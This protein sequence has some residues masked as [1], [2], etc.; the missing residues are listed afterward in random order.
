MSLYRHKRSSLWW[1]SIYHQGRRIRCSTGTTDKEKARLYHAK[2]TSDLWK[3]DKLQVT[4][5]HTWQ[6]ATM[7]WLTL[8]KRGQEDTYRLRW[9][10]EH[11]ELD[12]TPL[13][14]I[15][16]RTISHALRT[17]AG[18]GTVRRYVALIHTIL[19][20]ARQQGWL[21]KVPALYRPPNPPSRVRWMT[22]EDWLRLGP[23]LPPHLRQLARFTLATGLRRHNATHLAWEQVNLERR[24]AWVAAEHVKQRETLGIPLNDDALQVLREQSGQHARWVF[25]YKGKPVRLTAT[26]AWRSALAQAG[27]EDFTWHDLRH[28][29]A[30]WHVMNGTTL[31]EL[32]ELGGWKTLAM[33]KRYAHLAPGHLSRVAGNVRPVSGGVP[34]GVPNDD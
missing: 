4:P 20:T 13:S 1:V 27:I 5:S 34:A 33:V 11:T 22:E 26:K 19:E 21:T 10:A 12:R 9:L 3:E 14:E 24:H 15:T 30:S 7:V 2:L 32:M 8:R 28:T 23:L 29:W 25:P 31:G 16:A 17:K 18:A 6:D